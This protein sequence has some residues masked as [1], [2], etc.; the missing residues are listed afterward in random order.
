M[1]SLIKLQDGQSGYAKVVDHVI[2]TGEHRCPRGQCTLDAGPVM[3]ELKTP[4][5]AL[6][7]GVGRNVS[8]EVAALEALQLVG[9]VSMPD[10]LVA[11]APR[12]ADFTEDDGE[13]WG[14][15]GPRVGPQLYSI[16]QKLKADPQT[17]QAVMTV[18]NPATDNV[19]GKKDY[20]CTV[21]LGFELALGQLNM[22]V[23][24]R[25][26][27]VWLGIPYDWFQFTQLQ[28]TV[29]RILNAFPGTYTHTSWS[30]HLYER[31][32]D[33][34]RKLVQEAPERPVRV[35]QPKGVG[36]FDDPPVEVQ[37]R[38]GKIL[39]GQEVGGIT[40]DEEWYVEQ[41]RRVR[42]RLDTRSESDVGRD[43][44]RGGAGDRAAE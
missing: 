13:F 12:F 2:K 15:Y 24:M 18:W 9:G 4:W 42:D 31:N 28:F 38:A 6:A 29:A 30:L 19:A 43:L 39:R 33:A 35:H 10:L 11:A 16:V 20:P 7:V 41:V 32:L 3:M 22:H 21:A 23:T 40:S 5:H 44:D 25:S 36:R 37:R 34:A 1:A 26:S 17:R 14:S 8:T 27:D